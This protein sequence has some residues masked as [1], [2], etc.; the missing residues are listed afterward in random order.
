MTV[1][2]FTAAGNS[3]GTAPTLM[4]VEGEI[5]K[6]INKEVGVNIEVCCRS[7][8]A[9]KWTVIGSVADTEKAAEWM[10]EN[11]DFAVEDSA[12]DEELDENFIYIVRR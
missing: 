8:D 11:L 12:F 6:T 7:A 1:A 9:S 5:A 2:T 4:D 10:K 3:R